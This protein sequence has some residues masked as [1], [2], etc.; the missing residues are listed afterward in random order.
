[1]DIEEAVSDSESLQH[2]SLSP[3]PHIRPSDLQSISSG[4]TPDILSHTS[5]STTPDE[6]TP[7]LGAPG[8]STEPSSRI[9]TEEPCEPQLVMS[10]S[11]FL[12]AKTTSQLRRSISLDNCDLI[13]NSQQ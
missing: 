9:V 3:V 12:S 8:P 1:M 7:A 6:L 4:L 10:T 13:A 5:R 2:R 11:E